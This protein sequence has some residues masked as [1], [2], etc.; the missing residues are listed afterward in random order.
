VVEG[1]SETY[2][3]LNVARTVRCIDDEACEEVQLYTP[4][5]EEPDRVG[6]YSSVSGLRIDK[7]KVGDVR[8]FRLWGWHPPIIVDGGIKEAL[9]RTGIVGGRFDEV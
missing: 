2:Y 3:L 8:V 7:S 9:E 5:D 6:E 4:E 1:Q